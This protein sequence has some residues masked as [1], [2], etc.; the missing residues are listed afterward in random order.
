MAIAHLARPGQGG[1]ARVSPPTTCLAALR[2]QISV[3]P[4]SEPAPTPSDASLS[5]QRRSARP[6][7]HSRAVRH[8]I[9]NPTTETRD[10]R[11]RHRRVY[12]GAADLLAHVLHD[13]SNRSALVT[14]PRPG[15]NSVSLSIVRS[16]RSN[17]ELKKDFPPASTPSSSIDPRPSSL[18]DHEV[19]V[20][21]SWASFCLWAVRSLSCRSGSDDHP[22]IAIPRRPGRGLSR[23]LCGA[24][25][26]RSQ[27]VALFG[28]GSRS[29][30]SSN[31]G[32]SR[33]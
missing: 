4:A 15:A 33:R 2:A 5:D 9:A 14:M 31:D 30:S 11:P 21:F 8:I 19:I 18:I 25:G 6:A 32:E 16:C 7:V 13:R 24:F 27:P 22:V 29:A 20:R 12:I 23:S 10:L 17:A 28:L 3:S 26:Y 1:G